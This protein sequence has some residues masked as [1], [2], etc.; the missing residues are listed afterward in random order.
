M[1]SNDEYSREDE[2]ESIGSYGVL[3]VPPSVP[4]AGWLVSVAGWN[5]ETERYVTSGEGPILE[6]RD[7]AMR[8]AERVIDWLQS[9]D[10]ELDP[11]LVWERMQRARAAEER[12]DDPPRPWGRF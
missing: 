8:E 2:G 9:G 7:E 3:I 12:G 11:V 4:E 1:H 5:P 6:T 10:I